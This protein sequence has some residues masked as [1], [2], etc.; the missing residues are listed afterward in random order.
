MEGADV[1]DAI[2]SGDAARLRDLLAGDAALASS[3]DAAGVSAIMHAVYRQNRVALDLL[4]QSRPQL[5]VFEATAVGDVA[6]LTELIAAD[7]SLVNARSVDGFTPLHFAAYFRQE[8]AASL[9]LA[10]GAE[11]AAVAANP[12]QVMPLHSAASSRNL[13]V[14][15]ELL[16]RGA[17]VNARQQQ[18]WTALHAAAQ[19]GDPDMVKAL[20]Q[21]GADPH[22][23]NDDGKTPSAVA[24][25]KGH[26]RI[27]EQLQAA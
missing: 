24:Q 26:T 3:R 11:V 2:Q 18:G 5:D 13:P 23:E 27:V 4:L 20:L 10:Q 15:I 22:A 1:V 6:R 14:V 8:R 7:A 12:T 17:P 9:L 21:Y 16:K 25:E 19:N